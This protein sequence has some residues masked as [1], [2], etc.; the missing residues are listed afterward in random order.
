MGNIQ[1]RIIFSFLCL[2]FYTALSLPF[3]LIPFDFKVL[4]IIA[5]AC[6]AIFNVFFIIPAF[7]YS[8]IY[9]IAICVLYHIFL[10]FIDFIR[11]FYILNHMQ[12]NLL[13]MIIQNA[14]VT[15]I[16][17]VGI[18]L[19]C[20]TIYFV[21]KYIK[22]KG[23]NFNINMALITAY[24]IVF[25]KFI[26]NAFNFSLFFFS[27]M[28]NNISINYDI[29]IYRLIHYTISIIFTFISVIVSYF[30]YIKIK[31]KPFFSD[32]NN[33]N[34]VNNVINVNR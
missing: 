3:Y 26:V 23:I 11:I 24:I 12:G 27:L 16:N 15:I 14:F 22:N 13:Y 29:I 10:T 8:P 21:K 9:S 18:I 5:S 28:V 32:I 4:N 20:L 30:I 17:I 1:N 25:I 2:V 33:L 19:T 34:K 31:D 7:L 6:T